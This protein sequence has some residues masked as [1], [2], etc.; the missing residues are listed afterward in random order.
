MYKVSHKV[1]VL[2]KTSCLPRPKTKASTTE[3]EEEEEKNG[4]PVGDEEKITKRLSSS[5]PGL[6]HTIGK[7]AQENSSSS[8][9]DGLLVCKQKRMTVVESPILLS[10]PAPF[11]GKGCSSSSMLAA[12]NKTEAQSGGKLH[13]KFQH[14]SCFKVDE[15]TKLLAEAV[16]AVLKRK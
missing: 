6:L 15:N 14:R 9:E 8:L 13:C 1:C 2:N 7:P 12:V 5:W 16:T 11:I 3:E 4:C 10:S